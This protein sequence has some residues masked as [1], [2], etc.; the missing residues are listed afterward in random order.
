MACDGSLLLLPV[1]VH[2]KTSSMETFFHC[3]APS[4]S[5]LALCFIQFGA[6]TAAD[7]VVRRRISADINEQRGDRTR[8]VYRAVDSR[9]V[10]EAHAGTVATARPSSPPAY[11]S[12][13]LPQV[14]ASPTSELEALPSL[15][16]PDAHQRQHPPWCHCRLRF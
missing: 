5:G 7:S 4:G 2:G 9:R 8:T 1:M 6:A 15:A 12:Y 16:E 11:S 10:C 14:P 13:R 3:A